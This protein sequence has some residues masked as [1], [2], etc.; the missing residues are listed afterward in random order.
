MFTISAKLAEEIL[1]TSGIKFTAV[2]TH[3]AHHG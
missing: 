3:Q 2:R 1:I